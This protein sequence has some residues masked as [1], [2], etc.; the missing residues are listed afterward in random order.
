LANETVTGPRE[1]WPDERAMSRA[2]A[3]GESFALLEA[4]R[5]ARAHELPEPAE[6]H[7][8]PLEWYQQTAR[9]LKQEARD[10]GIDGG[11][12]LTNRW[13]IVYATGLLHT[14]TERPFACFLPMDEDAV[15]WFHPYLDT[16]LVRTWWCTQAFA[17]FDYPHAD[18][19]WPSRGEVGGERTTD[20]HRWWGEKLAELGY[21]ARTIGI[22]SGASAELGLMPG[23]ESR[24][25]YDFFAVEAPKPQRP[26]HGAFGR[27]ADALPEAQF[28]DVYD[29]LVRRRAQKGERETRLARRALD[30]LSEV[31]AFARD[32]LLERGLGTIDWE[33]GNAARTWGMHR[34]L[35]ELRPGTDPH[36]DAGFWFVLGC[37]SGR[38]TA[39]PH[40]NQVFWNRIEEGD[41][42]QI[43]GLL[44][45]GG[46]GGELYRS[47]LVA[48]WTDW[49]EHVWN[50]HTRSYEI[51]AEE[52]YA[53]NTGAAVA[54]A[55]H[56]HHVDN[57]CAQLVYHRPGHGQG[58]EGHQPPY[59]AL[60]DF[61]VLR[62]GMHFSNEPGLYDVEH[63]FGFNHGNTILVEEER[64]V[65]LGTAPATREWCLVTLR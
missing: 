61:T 18:T 25:R 40:P 22:D 15:V 58:S 30:Y 46:Y 56:R 2:E 47:F 60:G 49:Q 16:E 20:V 24:A 23:H 55:V 12:F 51:Q 33:V 53:G 63:G 65:Q 36:T 57:G 44:N 54:Q 59:H 3:S 64:G 27:M 52:S 19:G 26:Q 39:Y 28:V 41:A 11:I 50:V 62:A 42:L 43:A 45:L 10:R 37:R 13:N 5:A 9:E 14:T 38:S 48:P 31:H 7:R 35:E 34:V 4:E 21:G 17:Y 6:E 32:Y 29:I 1:T 8:L